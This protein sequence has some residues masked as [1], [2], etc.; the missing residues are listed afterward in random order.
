MH[1]FQAPCYQ[2]GGFGTLCIEDPYDANN[3]VGKSSYGFPTVKKA[4]E[5]A[6]FHLLKFVTP[7]TTACDDHL[8][9]LSSTIIIFLEFWEIISD[10][11]AAY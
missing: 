9:Y 11:F 4:F 6:Y 7:C 1:A 8:R 5:C 3:D 2:G 10:S